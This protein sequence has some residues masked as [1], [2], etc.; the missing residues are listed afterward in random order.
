MCFYNVFHCDFYPL[1][2]NK[3]QIIALAQESDGA[4]GSGSLLVREG[5][6]AAS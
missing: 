5:P 4:D 2:K 3:Q 6:T 1:R